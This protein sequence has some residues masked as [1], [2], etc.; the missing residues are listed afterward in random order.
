MAKIVYGLSGEGSGHSSR[1]REIMNY[2]ISS[3]HEVKAVSYDR[4]YRNLKDD[5][6]VLE[7]VG[8]RMINDENRISKTKTL[9]ENI[10]NILRGYESQERVKELLFKK[11]KPDCVITDFEPITAYLANYFDIPL[12]TIDNQHRFRYMDFPCPDSMKTDALLVE[13]LIRAIVPRPCISLITT[14]YFGKV[15][16]NR[17]ILF[18]PILREKVFKVKTS[19][20]QHILV[21]VT[22]AYENLLNILK[23]FKREKF[24]V[25][26]YQR[27]GK[28][29][30]LTLKRFS[31]ITFLR[32]LASCKAIIGTAGFTLI[33]E[34]LHLKKPY[35]SI[36]VKGQFEQIMNAIMLE[37]LG[38]G[39]NVKE[40]CRDAISA[41]FYE[42]PEY[43]IKL[44][45]YKSEDNSKITGK[46]DELLA[47]NCSLLREYHNRRTKTILTKKT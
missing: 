39:K 36:P 23:K 11:F 9:T 29:E 16:N 37:Q 4:G 42:L 32:D 7:V 40:M 25:Y 45:D 20:K 8:L 19:E 46:L 21:Y 31:R 44:K 35:C 10:S 28:D 41:F 14:Y 12:I 17:T 24:Y 22:Q 38:Y 30:N 6:D 43:Q 13:N 1:S 2:L 27:S 3:G 26:G 15:R 47:D 18:P 5:F 33:T 34:S